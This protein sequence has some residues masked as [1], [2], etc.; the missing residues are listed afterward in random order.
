MNAVPTVYHHT[1]SLRTNEI[2][3]SG[4]IKLEGQQP[5]A[6]HPKLGTIKTDANRRRSMTDFAPLVWFTSKISVPRCLV[7]STMY[8]TDQETGEVVKRV[9]LSELESNAMSLH[10]IALGFPVPAIPVVPW[11]DHP[12]YGTAEGQELNEAAREVGDD[13]KDWWV[14][15]EPVDVLAASEV[16]ICRSLMDVKLRRHDGYLKEVKKM[17]EACRTTKGVFIPPSWLSMKEAEKLSR[18]VGVPISQTSNLSSSKG[19]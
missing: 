15:D 11:P 18:M 19:E 9:R 4:K 12:G 7:E 1:S 6:L 14:S 17:V 8:F 5:E 16:W 3:M 10:R 2:W 13:P